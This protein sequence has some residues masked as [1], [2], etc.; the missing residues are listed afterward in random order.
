MKSSTRA[1]LV[2]GLVAL[3]LFGIAVWLGI[4]KTP[5]GKTVVTVRVWDEQVATAYRSSFGEFS[6]RNPEIEVTVNVTS[7][8][9]YFN[10][11][12]TDVAG[13]G[14]DDIF[15]VNSGYLSDYSD[16]GNLIPVAPHADWDPS[17]VAQF[18]RGGKLWGVPQ[19]SD[20]GIALY[21]NKNLLDEALVDPAEL[22][23]LRWDADPSVDTLRPILHRLTGPGHWG[24]NA[25]NDLQGIYLNY[26]GSAGTVFQAD[27]RFAF[28]N[29]RAQMAFTYLVDLIN[30]DKVAPSAADTN[31]NNDFSRNQFLQG[32]MALF[33]SGT[34]N[35]AQIQA[36]ATFP[37]GV[38]MMPAG[39]QGRVS[40]TNGIVA[41]ANS[42]SAHPEAV[43]RVLTWMGSADG[44]AFLGRDGAAVPAVL[45]A[46]QP[47]FQHW[48]GKGVDVAPFFEVLNGPQI[49]APNGRGYGAGFAAL[50]PYFAEMFLGRLDV[51][52][53]LQ[54][55][56]QAANKALE[57]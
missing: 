55:A 15:W 36:N 53:A 27:D 39:P 40:V 48:A 3:L 29:P 10:S 8:A 18:T 30:V 45:S 20:A 32:R 13:H 38:A 51:H 6:R 49:A 28:A 26:L 14:A 9:S 11:L 24:Y 34:Y 5:H 31:D 25:A 33:Q 21:Y 46:R 12:R 7:Y 37:W 47:Y 54:Q 19:L 42:S 16:T 17:V 43:Q 44:N 57:R 23:E 56:Q 35:L 1:V 22:A 2:L 50:K 41:A 52:T 4:P